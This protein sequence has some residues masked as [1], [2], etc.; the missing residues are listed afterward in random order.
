MTRLNK[1]AFFLICSTV[2]VTT[3]AYG[4]V[5]QPII[6]LFY[7]MVATMVLLWTVDCYVIGAIRFSRSP[8]QIP[9][10]LFGLYGTVQIIPF[11]T[12]ADAAG[13]TNIPL[14]ISFEPF[15]T[16]VTVVHIFVLCSFY[17][18][19][20]VYLES[21]GRLRRMVMVITVFGFIYA[22]YTILQSVL[23]PAKIY[24]IYGLP[25]STP[26]GSFVNRNDFAAIIEM[27]V[28]V[29][30]GMIFAGAVSR[31]KRLLYVVAIILMAA[32]LM[33]SGSRGGLVAFVSEIIIL[34]ILT[35]R[36][37]GSK[38]IVLKAALSLLLV[39]AAV[40][41]AMFVGG[42]TSLT[43]FTATSSAPD[44]TSNRSVIWRSTLKMIASNLPLGSGLGAYGQA[45]T[46][47]D[48]LSGTH[49]VEQAH[50]DYLQVL[51]DAGVVGLVIGA[52]FLFWFFR[53]GIRNTREKN[54]FRRG[55]AVGAFAGCFAILIHSVFDFVLHIT[56]I[57][58]TFLT[59]MSMLVASGRK[60]EDDINDFD[61]M[62]P[63][64]RSSA[65]V[66]PI[67]KRQVQS[68]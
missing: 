51:A 62:P 63:K 65:S 58:V 24:G 60:Y 14:T 5:H 64:R 22:F 49:R 37:K 33:L 56:A 26:F 48:T 61:E 2:V 34:I 25:F 23:S 30:L 55:V 59:L 57:S 53:Q 54:R 1:T 18:M 12:F 28:G 31:D 10:L 6:A 52:L 43:R 45:F 40:G 7:L 15:A 67:S 13:L 17:A 32:A 66:T 21:A 46:P 8:L 4:T 41:G 36:T 38:N 9:L 42:D 16:Q 39:G 35:T 11:G 29:P 50:N 27:T 47:F 3:L 19:A 68:A 20:L 44:I